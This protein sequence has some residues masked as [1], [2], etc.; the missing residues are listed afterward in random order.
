[1]KRP[2]HPCK[3][4]CPKRKGGCR[5]TCPDWKEYEI[6]HEAYMEQ[7]EADWKRKQDLALCKKR[8]GH[9]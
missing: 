5:I 6:E 9:W 7:V 8:R 3:K 1:M 4:D 2:K